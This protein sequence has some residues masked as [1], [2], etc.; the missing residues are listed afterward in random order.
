V[1]GTHKDAVRRKRVYVYFGAELL[2]QAA[3]KCE[4]HDCTRP[5]EW[6]MASTYDP[7]SQYFDDKGKNVCENHLKSEIDRLIHE[8]S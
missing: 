8:A 1:A 5:A 3:G 4:V 6:N 7:G 2:Q